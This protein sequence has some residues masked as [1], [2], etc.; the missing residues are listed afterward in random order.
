MFNKNNKINLFS[1]MVVL[2]S[3]P[4]FKQTQSYFQKKISKITSSASKYRQL[5]L[6]NPT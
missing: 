4:G 1:K 5:R 6:E 2:T 3:S